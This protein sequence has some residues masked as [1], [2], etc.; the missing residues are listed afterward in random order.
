MSF[1][2]TKHVKPRFIAIE[3][4]C[5]LTQEKN[6]ADLLSNEVYAQD[7]TVWDQIELLSNKAY[8]TRLLAIQKR[9][10]LTLYRNHAKHLTNEVDIYDNTVIELGIGS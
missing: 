2:R 6:L 8:L 9:C 4:H 1:N 3:Q 7:N 5:E 10:E